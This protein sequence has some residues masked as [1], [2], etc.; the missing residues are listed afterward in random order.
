[1]APQEGMD[2]K[3]LLAVNPQSDQ[4]GTPDPGG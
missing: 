4:R 3:D 2:P 1:M